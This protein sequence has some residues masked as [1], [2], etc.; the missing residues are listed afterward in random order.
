M[1]TENRLWL[2]FLRVYSGPLTFTLCLQ[3]SKE[4]LKRQGS[5]KSPWFTP[6]EARMMP[7][8]HMKESAEGCDRKF[9]FVIFFQ[10][11]L[12]LLLKGKIAGHRYAFRLVSPT[13]ANS[14]SCKKEKICTFLPWQLFL[15]LTLGFT[16]WAKQYIFGTAVI[17]PTRSLNLLVSWHNSS[18]RDN[19]TISHHIFCFPGG[20]RRRA[21]GERTWDET[22]SRFGQ[23]I[24][25][26]FT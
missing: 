16:C 13:E 10:E 2:L 8:R 21:R 5:Q 25:G 26:S 20:G 14:D 3:K 11:N 1:K 9:L 15:Q 23:A 6:P 12:A 7:Q 4:T 17:S 19:L 18:I 24:D 22:F